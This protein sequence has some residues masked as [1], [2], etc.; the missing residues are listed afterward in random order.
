M[1][2]FL[3]VSAISHDYHLPFLHQFL[4]R[5]CAN[6]PEASQK[7]CKTYEFAPIS[8]PNFTKLTR[9]YPNF[10]GKKVKND[11]EKSLL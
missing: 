1:K 2:L 8:L 10:W 9:I 11:K 6:V 4:H 7:W 5:F 3:F